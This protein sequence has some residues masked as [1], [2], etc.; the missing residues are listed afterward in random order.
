M[1]TAPN[2]IYYN[3]YIITLSRLVPQ[4]VDNQRS[5]FL[6]FSLTLDH[7]HLLPSQLSVHLDGVEGGGLGEADMPGYAVVA[8]L[9]PSNLWLQLADLERWSWMVCLGDD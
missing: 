6:Y 7:L 9:G 5:N 1:T 4:V 2:T 3:V 8:E